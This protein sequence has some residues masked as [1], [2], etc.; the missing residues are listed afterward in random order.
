MS[1]DRKSFSINEKMQKIIGDQVMPDPDEVGASPGGKR[2]SPSVENIHFD[3]IPEEL[4]DYLK[5]YI[6]SQEHSIEIVATKICTHFHRMQ[7]ERETPSLPRIV[8]HVKSNIILIGPTGVGKTYLVRLIANKLNVPFV[9]GDATKFSETG[10]VGGDVEDLVRELVH[11]VDENIDLAEYGIIYIDEIDKIASSGS[12][13]GPDVSRSGVQRNLLKLME[14]TEV[15]MKVPHDL[16]SQMEAVMET[17]RTGKVSRKKVNTRNILFIMSGAFSDLPEIIAKRLKRGGMGFTG[18]ALTSA[19]DVEFML[20]RLE[21]EDLITFGYESEF[22]GRI[23][24]MTFL[25]ELTEE[26]LYSIMQN[27]NSAVIQGK[28][29]DFT[30]Y[31]INLTFDDA[32]LK[33]VAK[34]ALKLHTGA[35]GLV[36]VVEKMLLPFE[37]SLPSTAI[38]RLH[39]TTEHYHNPEA[40][41]RE[42]IIEHSFEKVAGD[43]QKHTGVVLSYS[44]SVKKI[45]PSKADE[46]DISIIEYLNRILGDYEY[47]LKLAGVDRFTVT[48]NVINDSKGYLDKLIKKSYQEDR[49]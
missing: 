3:I 4:I 15:D 48:Q 23:P 43:F 24:V 28:K 30:A 27:P 36:T 6:V 29:R 45:V 22:V 11:Q 2:G 49:G 42:M 13:H 25:K 18:K 21:T 19:S 17:Q 35:R 20:E 44:P 5:H 39:Y 12:W 16:A 31:G 32:A 9:K 10:Y 7:L 8:G 14:E 47:G 33:L 40:T 34:D 1:E 41:L 46:A 38:N 26:G 37:R